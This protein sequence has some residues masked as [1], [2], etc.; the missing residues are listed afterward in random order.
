MEFFTPPTIYIVMGAI[1]VLGFV[2]GVFFWRWKNKEM[3]KPIK[4]AEVLAWIVASAWL[5]MMIYGT[6]TQKFKIP[7][8]FDIIGGM[9]ISHIIGF[10][11]VDAI[12]K[13]GFKK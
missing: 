9:A 12:S 8:M 2:S 4:M 3:S 1:Y 6:L 10:N 5:F 11:F 7:V 13:I